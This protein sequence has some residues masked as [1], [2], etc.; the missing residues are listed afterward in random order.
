M[1]GTAYDMFNQMM[2]LNTFFVTF[3]LFAGLREKSVEHQYPDQNLQYSK[4]LV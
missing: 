3:W 1:N 2:A 4:Q